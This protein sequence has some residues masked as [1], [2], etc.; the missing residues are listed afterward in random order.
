[1]LKHNSYFDG[2]VQSIGFER[3]ARRQTVGVIETGEYHFDTRAPE[4]MHVITGEIWMRINNHEWRP[5]PAGTSF[6]IP[7]ETGFDVRVEQPSAYWCEFL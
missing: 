3:N 5:Y 6:E 2:G 1:M 4:R 7:A